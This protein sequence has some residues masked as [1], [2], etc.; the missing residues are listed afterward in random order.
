MS[1]TIRQSVTF[2]ATPH[3][4]YEAL[5]D[6]RKHAK[7]TGDTASISRKVGGKIMAYG[8]YITGTNVELV[9]DEK[10]VQTWHAADWPEGHESRATFSLKPIKGGARL[11]FTH[12]GV[13]D[14]QY[15]SIKQGWIEHYW[16]PMKAMLNR[17]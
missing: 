10:I 12:T 15:E 16:T 17:D 11:T 7:F 14:D 5:M 8:G 2:K 9:P 4:V 6:S 13:P 1:K 3:Q